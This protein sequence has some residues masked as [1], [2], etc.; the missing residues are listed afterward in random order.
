MQDSATHEE[1]GGA[2]TRRELINYSDLRQ[3]LEE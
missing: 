2:E 3:R 1:Q